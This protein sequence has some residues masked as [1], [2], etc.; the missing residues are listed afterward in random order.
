MA[1]K[2]IAESIAARKTLR[3][4]KSKGR[5]TTFNGKSK[6]IITTKD[7]QA[8]HVEGDNTFLATYLNSRTGITKL[9]F[10]GL[11]TDTITSLEDEE[12]LEYDSFIVLEVGSEEDIDWEQHHNNTTVLDVTLTITTPHRP[13]S[14]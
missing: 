5:L 8:L 6:V 3:D 2:S 11:V 14:N 13:G 1:G 12:H 9:K 4:A 10:A 7:G